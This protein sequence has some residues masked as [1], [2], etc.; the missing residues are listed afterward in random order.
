MQEDEKKVE[1][2]TPEV[3]PTATVASEAV[4]SQGTTGTSDNDQGE[5]EPDSSSTLPVEN[6]PSK[7]ERAESSEEDGKEPSE[8]SE[9]VKEGE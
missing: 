8:D 1:E 2:A 9:L 7:G 5:I 3:D 4:P 6:E